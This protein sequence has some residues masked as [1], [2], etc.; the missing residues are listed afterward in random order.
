[1]LRGEDS[2][3]E[4]IAVSISLGEDA[5]TATGVANTFFLERTTG[6]RN[7]HGLHDVTKTCARATRSVQFTTVR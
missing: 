3:E 1:M 4:N 5:E 7:A 6:S 2:V